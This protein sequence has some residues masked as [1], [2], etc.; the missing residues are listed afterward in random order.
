MVELARTILEAGASK[1]PFDACSI[2]TPITFG[3]SPLRRRSLYQAEVDMRLR[4][5]MTETELMRAG[6]Q[7]GHRT[8]PLVHRTL[9]GIYERHRR[10]VWTE[11]SIAHAEAALERAGLYQRVSR[12]PAICFVD[13]AGYPV[14][15]RSEETRSRQGSRRAWPHS[16]R[17]SPNATVGSRSG[18]WGMAACSC[19]RNRPR[20]WWPPWRWWTALQGRD[21]RPPT[22]ASMQALLSPRTATCSAGRSTSQRGSRPGPGPERSS[23]VERRSSWWRMRGSDSSA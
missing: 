9:L 8:A 17:T 6:S 1:G 10:H 19:S 18:G 12:P 22:S 15:P 16:S 11:I 2:S 23:R 4:Q 5:G 20:G 14:S 21:C 13:L 7:L 3:G